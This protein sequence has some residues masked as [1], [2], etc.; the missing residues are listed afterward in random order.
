MTAFNIL[1]RRNNTNYLT[2]SWDKVAGGSSVKITNVPGEIKFLISSSVQTS[3]LPLGIYDI[4]I[5]YYTNV[6]TS[7]IIE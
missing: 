4:R 5:V 6:G 2:W 3:A 7:D 1:L